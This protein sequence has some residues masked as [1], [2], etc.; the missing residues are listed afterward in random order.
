METYCWSV[1][2]GQNAIGTP[3]TVKETRLELKRRFALA[4]QTMTQAR[5]SETLIHWAITCAAQKS[6]PLCRSAKEADQKGTTIEIDV[7]GVN[8]ARGASRS[9]CPLKR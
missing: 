1:S 9:R 6:T 5:F 7:S 4:E 2:S 8:P 3:E